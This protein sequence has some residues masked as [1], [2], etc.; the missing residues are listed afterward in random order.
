MIVHSHVRIFFFFSSRRRHTRCL[1]DWSSD[2]CSSDLA[3]V[4]VAFIV[5]ADPNP[6]DAQAETLNATVTGAHLADSPVIT[7]G[8][9]NGLT[10]AAITLGQGPISQLDAGAPPG[11]VFDYVSYSNEIDTDLMDNADGRAHLYNS[12]L[13]QEHWNWLL[14][15]P[16][17]NNNYAS[18]ALHFRAAPP[19]P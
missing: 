4:T 14:V 16:T 9:L 2:V 3:P 13:T 8:S 12:D 10:I 15:G 18:V 6:V 7:P 17:A 11:A 19:A 1:S 5:G